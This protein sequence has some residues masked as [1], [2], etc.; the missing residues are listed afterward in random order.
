MTRG[1]SETF[2]TNVGATRGPSPEQFLQFGL[3][4]TL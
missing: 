1:P 3:P 4:S 2:K